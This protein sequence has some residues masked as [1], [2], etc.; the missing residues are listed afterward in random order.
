M[1]ATVHCTDIR[2][3]WFSEV[4]A[5]ETKRDF[6]LDYFHRLSDISMVELI[7]DEPT[8]SSYVEDLHRII[9]GGETTD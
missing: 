4:E 2:F 1:T 3:P 6:L 8:E 9:S 7:R 5:W